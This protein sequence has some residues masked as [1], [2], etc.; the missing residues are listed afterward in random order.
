MDEQIRSATDSVL[1]LT[2]QLCKQHQLL[3]LP[4]PLPQCCHCF[5]GNYSCLCF[6]GAFLHPCK[7]GAVGTVRVPSHKLTSVGKCLN[8][9]VNWTS[10]TRENTVMTGVYITTPQVMQVML[11][12]AAQNA[13]IV[14]M[15][16]MLPSLGKNNHPWKSTILKLRQE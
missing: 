11:P 4:P 7:W 3:Q 13:L 6:I 2:K 15:K 9:L 16:D 12:S 1:L 14:R 10:H 5:S 8:V